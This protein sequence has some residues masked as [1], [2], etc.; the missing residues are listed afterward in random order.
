MS[1]IP[2]FRFKYIK[3]QFIWTWRHLLVSFASSLVW[4]L[5]SQ[6]SISAA[7]PC[8]RSVYCMRSCSSP[9]NA[10]AA[11][12][13][14][15]VP[16]SCPYC[17]SIFLPSEIYCFMILVA[18]LDS[19]IIGILYSSWIPLVIGP[20]GLLNRIAD[21]SYII[22]N[23]PL[24]CVRCSPCN[25]LLKDVNWTLGLLWAAECLLGCLKLLSC[26]SSLLSSE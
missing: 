12:N 5:I 19:F 14:F 7:L 10:I 18:Q 26:F 21:T 9:N 2:Q 8:Y 20:F 13:I 1:L 17:L 15:K 11:V 22:T 25:L 16:S 4:I 23:Y 24:H 3:N 6:F